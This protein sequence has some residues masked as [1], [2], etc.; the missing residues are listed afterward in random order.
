MLVPTPQLV[1]LFWE[2]LG[3]ALLKEICHWGWALRFQTP[4]Q[5]PVIHLCLVVVSQCVNSQSLLQL[6]ISLPVVMLP[7]KMVTG[8]P[9]EMV[10]SQ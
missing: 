6:H 3:V 9:S 8:S 5:S 10:R 2:E 4:T 1:E 7:T